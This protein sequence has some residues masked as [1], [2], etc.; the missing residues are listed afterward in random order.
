MNC[1]CLEMVK[2]RLV[3]HHKSEV[4]LELSMWLNTESM[5][6]EPGFQPLRYTY[7]D[8]KKRKKSH[9]TFN[10]CPICGNRFSKKVPS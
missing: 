9:V 7:R 1:T 5:K 2:Q 3:E 4:D 10:F 6:S 8:G